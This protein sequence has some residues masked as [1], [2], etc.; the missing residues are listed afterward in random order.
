M[1]RRIRK[2]RAPGDDIQPHERTILAPQ[3]NEGESDGQLGEEREG[4]VDIGRHLT[5]FAGDSRYRS[6]EITS[7][8]S[9][10]QPDRS[11]SAGPTHGTDK[12]PSETD[13]DNQEQ[14]RKQRPEDFGT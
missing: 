11:G 2:D 9:R 10:L 14:Q 8:R 5:P 7:K 13:H 1:E 4:P 12:G 6:Q 3:V